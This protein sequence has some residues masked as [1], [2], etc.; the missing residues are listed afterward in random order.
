MNRS[1]PR[2]KLVRVVVADPSVGTR[3]LESHAAHYVHRVHRLG[4]GDGFVAVDPHRGLE[5]E[6][7]IDSASGDRVTCTF[8][9]FRQ[10]ND[11][12]EVE[13]MLLVAL[14]KGEKLERVIDS[15]C[16]LGVAE[17]VVLKSDRS[18]VRLDESK[19]AERLARWTRVLEQSAR[20]CG[21]AKIP[22][23]LGP[24]ACVDALDLALE[25]RG[26]SGGV[27]VLLEPEADLDFGKLLGRTAET[28]LQLLVG[29]EGGFSD[30]ERVAADERGFVSARLGP[31]T[32]RTETAAVAAVAAAVAISGARGAPRSC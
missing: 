4:S 22:R 7:V 1:A 30:P 13:V 32:L 23:L 28:T 11:R 2:S 16:Q 8:T 31:L 29:P 6:A 25:A 12:H 3:Q 18:V 26:V 5:S 27:G 14:S 24:V 21:R 9:N 15:A 17:I 10:A 19:S 20:Q